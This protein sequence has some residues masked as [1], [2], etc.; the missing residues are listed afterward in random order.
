M[1]FRTAMTRVAHLRARLLL[2][3]L[4]FAC[5]LL[6]LLW[7]P[8][9]S[10][11]D[12]HSELSANSQTARNLRAAIAAE[13]QRINATGAGVRQAQ[14]R[15][16]RL[17][18]Q[19]QAREAQLA[20][21]ERNIIAA[22][23]RL[24]HLENR[25]HLAAQALEA[26]LRASY[27]DPAPDVVTVV[28]ESHGFADMLEQLALMQ[29]VQRHNQQVVG[30]TRAARNEVLGQTERL[31]ALQV[32]DRALTASVLQARDQA[33]AI[34]A[35]LLTRQAQQMQARA[36]SAAR[37]ASVRG[38]IASI[39]HQIAKLAQAPAVVT[40]PVDG[41]PLDPGGYA[42]APAGAPAAVRQVIAAGNA[43]AGL[44]YLYGG[45]HGSFHANAYDCSGSVSYALAAAGLLSSPLDSTAFESW[46]E[47]GPG[48][49]IT[50]YANA[51]H[52][53]MVVAGWRFDTVALASGG[54]RWSRTMTS[55]A[56]FVARHPAG[57]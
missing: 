16:A 46:G 45:G 47:A 48:K 20:G 7:N 32:R 40:H 41:L 38:R 37:L 52:A 3:P 15:L 30:D 22:R 27:E 21:V 56:G 49:W 23:V 6:V 2:L 54:T 28:L 8:V 36:N 44:P 9:A 25:L 11:G 29:R 5:G 51:G 43:I 50:V 57:L 10:R 13:T 34:Q 42:Q 39:K 18:A 1:G 12:L 24:E 53:F 14:A 26:N 33:A 4:A 19:A 35:A 55:T 31:Q 17:Q